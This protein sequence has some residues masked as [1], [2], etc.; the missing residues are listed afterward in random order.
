MGKRRESI[1]GKSDGPDPAIES[2][3][4]Y[5]YR[6]KNDAEHPNI[7]NFKATFLATEERIGQMCKILLFTEGGNANIMFRAMVKLVE[8]DP[9]LRILEL[10]TAGDGG[11]N[12]AILS[13]IIKPYILQIHNTIPAK[14]KGLDTISGGSAQ[15]SPDI[16]RNTITKIQRDL[17]NAKPKRKFLV[18]CFNNMNT[19]IGVIEPPNVSIGNVVKVLLMIIQEY[20]VDPAPESE[21]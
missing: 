6:L 9:E 11:Y 12:V 20:I 4:A 8:G 7:E 14:N 19:E 17:N 15:A 18:K 3:E 2:T 1:G 13:T 21:N 10:K 5:I 16:T